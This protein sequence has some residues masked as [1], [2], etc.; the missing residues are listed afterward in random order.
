MVLPAVAGRGLRTLRG[1]PKHSLR[2]EWFG[3]WFVVG[4][5]GAEG[6][7]GVEPGVDELGV[8]VVRE[9]RPHTGAAGMCA[10]VLVRVLDRFPQVTRTIRH[11]TILAATGCQ[12]P[13]GAT[14][15][16]SPPIGLRERAS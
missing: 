3:F 15:R 11:A 12:M 13:P 5:V 9:L 8:A 10:D 6:F 16:A 7:D 1:A 2:R 4:S 14:L